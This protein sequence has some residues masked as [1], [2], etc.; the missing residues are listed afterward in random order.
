MSFLDGLFESSTELTVAAVE[1]DADA[2]I[3]PGGLYRV[4]GNTATDIDLTLA[5]HPIAEVAS[6]RI[7]IKVID[8]V[9][10]STV[11]VAVIVPA[12]MLIESDDGELGTL[13]E[14]LQDPGTYREWLCD[15]A[16]T[17]WLVAGAASTGGGSEP[18]PVPALVI[19]DDGVP[20]GSRP[21]LNFQDAQ[22]TTTVITDDAESGSITVAVNA[23]VA[24]AKAGVAVGAR[25]RL[26]LL[27]GANV[28]ITAADDAAGDEVD[29]TI[30][31]SAP[32]ATG[33]AVAGFTWA[34][35]AASIN[36]ATAR[37]FAATN[38]LAANSVLTLTGGVDGSN[39]VIAVKHDG[40][41]TVYTLGF[42]VAGRTIRRD[43]NVPDTNPLALA[44]AETEYHYLFYTLAGVAYCRI[45]KA[46]LQ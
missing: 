10:E 6:K 28:T 19:K 24:I 11:Y 35:G 5:A 12:G 44:N 22:N 30:A 2:T 21:A 13:A 25:S 46:Y 37:V 29:V 31:A 26:N 8:A 32:P 33:D 42:T 27:E 7:A 34:A 40:T 39:G 23:K 36:V 4:L 17:W 38:A 20:V 15:A 1:L 18:E 14:C 43:L 3:E 41:T 45:F 9:P 16:G